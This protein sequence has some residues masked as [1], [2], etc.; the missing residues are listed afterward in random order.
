MQISKKGILTTGLV[1]VLMTLLFAMHA[2]ADSSEEAYEQIRH[3][4]S[5]FKAIFKY[6]K[7]VD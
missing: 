4:A 7:K 3:C 2:W 1:F 6:V 5:R